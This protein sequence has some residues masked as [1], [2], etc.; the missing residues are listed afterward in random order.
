LTRGVEDGYREAMP[1]R[2]R[3]HT[4]GYAYHVLNR[5]VGR[6]TLFHKDGDY[7]AF[8][9]ALYQAKEWL[10]VRLLAYC[11]MPNHWHLVLWPQRDAELS[12]FL[13]WL[14]VTHTQ[15][16]HAHYHSAG[17]G[18]L[19]QGRFKSFPI[20]DDDHL[21]TV[22]RYVERNAL[23]AG[24]VRQ[25]EDWHWSSLW[26]R[27][28]GQGLGLLDDGPTPLPAGWL[29]HVNG[30]ETEAELA[31]LRRSVARGRPFGD[32]P[33]VEWTAKRLG[34]ESTLRCQGRPRKT[35]AEVAI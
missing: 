28:A 6:A 10:P 16:Y 23:R 14:T 24:L 34:L 12:E 33:W 15:R 1:R 29:G 3:C 30:A 4:G 25:A 13:R 19:Y 9:K 11:L 20:Q 18:P 5:A 8:E 31:A 27:A 32:G 35:T 17:T 26:R 22:L 2:L 7:A 21:R